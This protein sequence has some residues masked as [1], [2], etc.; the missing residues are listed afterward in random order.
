M[1][2]TFASLAVLHDEQQDDMQRRGT[3]G[4]AG[5]V[6][7]SWEARRGERMPRKSKSQEILR[8]GSPESL[9]RAIE[10]NE[11][12]YWLYRARH[13]GWEIFEGPKL[14]WF[15]SGLHNPNANAVLRTN[16]APEETDA[17]IDGVMREMPG[18]GLPMIWWSGPG[19]RPLDLGERLLRRGFLTPGFDPGMAVELAA[20]SEDQP[21]PAGL[22]IERVRD[23]STLADWLR[24]FRL[25]N[26]EDPD[27][28]TVPRS[29][30]GPSSYDDDDPFHFYL[31][32]LDG[33]PVATSQM[34][35]G[36]GVAG[37][38]CV[39]TVPAA[40]RRGIGAAVT[41]APLRIARALGYR[42]GVLGATEMGYPVYQRL[43]FREYCKL[44][45]YVWRTDDADDEADDE[46]YME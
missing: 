32:R 8:D 40:R 22:R 3:L 9:I 1:R 23:D 41:L 21:V 43:G 10:E 20:L 27:G 6:A 34:V 12:A 2:P 44:S 14:T 31:A 19:R 4:H 24:A 30:L 36:A 39:A 17:A 11:V 46:A 38:Y 42:Y 28:P 18:R 45:M 33:E 29:R 25:G 7:A 35:L 26:E 15:R 16:L 13:S 5:G 37:L